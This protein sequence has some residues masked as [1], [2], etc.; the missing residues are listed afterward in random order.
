MIILRQGQPDDWNIFTSECHSIADYT[1]RP[2]YPT[3]FENIGCRAE[4]VEERL[5]KT[6]QLVHKWG[7]VLL[8]DEA[9]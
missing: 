4:K 5:E 6:F 2:L 7:C 3:S 1:N 9:I 8:F